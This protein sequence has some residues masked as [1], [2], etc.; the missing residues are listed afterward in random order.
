MIMTKNS[1]TIANCSESVHLLLL[2][3][4]DVRISYPVTVCTLV[5]MIWETRTRYKT[6]ATK[7]SFIS[8][9]GRLGPRSTQ[10]REFQIYLAHPNI[11]ASPI[12][13]LL[14][15]SQRRCTMQNSNDPSD[16]RRAKMAFLSFQV[17]THDRPRSRSWWENCAFED[18]PIISSVSVLDGAPLIPIFIFYY[19]T[20]I[21]AASPTP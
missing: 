9:T 5:E 13:E 12:T 21:L 15:I 6:S 16:M 4:S 20:C 8:P 3:R 14:G 10:P 2:E 17:D 7:K 18:Q 11:I 1:A 19:L